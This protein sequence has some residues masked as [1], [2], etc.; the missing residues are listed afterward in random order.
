MYRLTSNDQ[1]RYGKDFVPL[2]LE[3]ADILASVPPSQGWGHQCS[4]IFYVTL[5]P[6]PI[7][8]DFRVT[9]FGTGKTWG[10]GVFLYVSRAPVPLHPKFLWPTY[11][12]M[13]WCTA[14][15]FCMMIK[16]AEMKI[17][18]FRVN[19]LTTMPPA[20][21]ENICNTTLT[22]LQSVFLVEPKICITCLSYSML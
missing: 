18:T 21:S 19:Q 15:K 10:N 4:Q 20:L 14:T 16:L 7:D 13:I 1:I 17:L 5:L 11:V 12:R 2:S 22:D 3:T 9:K 8:S 6:M